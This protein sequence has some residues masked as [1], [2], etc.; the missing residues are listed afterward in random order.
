MRCK[1][2]GAVFTP[3]T[4]E[5]KMI[6][7]GNMDM[8]CLPCAMEEART[9]DAA[10]TALPY[11]SYVHLPPIKDF[12][13]LFRA[14][15]VNADGSVRLFVATPPPVPPPRGSAIYRPR[16]SQVQPFVMREQLVQPVTSQPRVRLKTNLDSFRKRKTSFWVK[17]YPSFQDAVTG[18]SHITINAELVCEEEITKTLVPVGR[19]DTIPLSDGGEVRL[20]YR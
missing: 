10:D 11:A 8:V 14:E 7:S 19:Q 3:S 12:R 13:N 4:E 2:C 9:R 20:F 1:K 18:T 16:K 6:A 17:K 5:E 15:Q